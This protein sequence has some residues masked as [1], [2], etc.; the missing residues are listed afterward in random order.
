MS[1]NYKAAEALIESAPKQHAPAYEKYFDSIRPV[2]VEETF[3][4]GIFAFASVHTTW[5][6]NIKLYALLWELNWMKDPDLLRD[7]IVDSR[8]GLVNGRT[9]NI[10]KFTAMFW[11]FPEQFDKKED[12]TWYAFRDRIMNLVS[13]LGPA[14]SAFFIEL[15]HFQDSRISCFDTHMLQAYGIK[16]PDVG[17]VKPADMA[18]MEMH[19]DLTCE[20]YDLNPV[21]CRWMLWDII[22]N[23]PNSKY[24]SYVLE[25]KPEIK[26]P[27]LELFTG[28]LKKEKVNG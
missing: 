10:M 18:R 28:K 14:K 23:K 8:A 5:E 26:D 16:P 11:Q 20:K 9:K 24:W 13:G 19:W 2:T 7:L 22:Q 12:E 17:N 27:Q 4:R 3:R 21:T 6:S 1:I 15:T 25:G